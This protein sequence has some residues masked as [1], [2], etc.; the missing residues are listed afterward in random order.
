VEAGGAKILIDAGKSFKA[1]NLALGDIGESIENIDAI[2]ITHEHHDHIS[3]LRTLSHK[4]KIPI[5][6]LISSAMI[7]RGLQDE[8]LCDCL[9]M[10][11]GDS[12]EADVK[13]LHVKAFPTPHDS[14]GAVGYRLT[15]DNGCEE[16]AIAVSTDIG[17]VTDTLKENL[18]GCRAIVIESNHDK[19]ML[20][21]G[22]YPQELKARIASKHGHLSNVECAALASELYSSGT[23]HILLAHLSEENNLP[24]LAYNETFASVAV[25]DLDLKVACQDEHVWLV[26]CTEGEK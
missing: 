18:T 12:F 6:I 14:M 17:F 15:F 2:F 19:E 11:K 3:A 8:K 16:C 10:H 22:P 26:G 4:H 1:L 20:K 24:E 23:R 13:G 5:H 7:F 9:V 21:N 25:D